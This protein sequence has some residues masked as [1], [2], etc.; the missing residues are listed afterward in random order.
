MVEQYPLHINEIDQIH[1]MAKTTAV[2][3]GLE[4]PTLAH[5]NAALH[6][7]KGCQTVPVLFG[8]VRV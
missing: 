4:T 1:K 5:V 7:Y 6:R 2:L 3:E 8:G